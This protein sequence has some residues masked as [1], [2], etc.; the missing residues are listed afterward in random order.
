[1][2]RDR[3]TP[4][5]RDAVFARDKRCIL[6]RLSDT[7]VCRDRWGQPHMPTATHLLTL[8]HVKTDLRIGLR[9]PSD[10]RHLVAMCAYSNVGVPS[11][12]E[13]VAIRAY[14]EEVNR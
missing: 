7:H 3:V 1:M 14:L 13:R 12:D 2:T 10:M 4:A 5:L 11:K 6:S 9:A 8:E